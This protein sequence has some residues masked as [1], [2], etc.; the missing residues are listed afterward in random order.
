MGECITVNFENRLTQQGTVGGPG[1]IEET[2][3][4]NTRLSMHIHI[5]GFD[6]LGS[7]G[8]V[9]GYDYMQ[10]TKGPQDNPPDENNAVTEYKL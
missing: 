3:Q 1:V 9:T 4:E 5:V 10:G 6:V 8:V 7:D 2:A